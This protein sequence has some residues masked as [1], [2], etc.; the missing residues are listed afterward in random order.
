MSLPPLLCLFSPISLVPFSF[1]PVLCFLF[2]SVTLPS[3]PLEKINFCCAKNLVLGVFSLLWGSY[4]HGKNI[5][6][7]N[8]GCREAVCFMS[9]KKNNLS[10]LTMTYY[11]TLCFIFLELFRSRWNFLTTFSAFYRNYLHLRLQIYCMYFNINIEAY[12]C[13]TAYSQR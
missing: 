13:Y 6:L 7:N 8:I 10:L 2:L 3:A 5:C 9:M 1:S 4:T 12:E 11:T